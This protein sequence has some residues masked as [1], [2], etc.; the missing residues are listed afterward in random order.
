MLIMCFINTKGALNVMDAFG[1][2]S[3]SFV[4][5]GV[6]CSGSERGLQDCPR[7]QA[8]GA[9]CSA[10]QDAGVVCQGKMWANQVAVLCLL[11][12]L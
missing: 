7:M 5:G 11:L 12:H 10:Y 9:S 6:N 1:E 8:S 3:L 4:L 2:N